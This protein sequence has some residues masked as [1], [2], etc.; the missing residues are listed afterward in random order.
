MLNS[1]LSIHEGGIH[2]VSVMK[3][4][5][6]STGKVIIHSRQFVLFHQLKILYFANTRVFLLLGNCQ[7]LPQKHK[8]HKRAL[9]IVW[10]CVFL[11]KIACQGC[12]RLVTTAT[13]CYFS[14]QEGNSWSARH[15][16]L[17]TKGPRFVDVVAK[18]IDWLKNET[19]EYFVDLGFDRCDGTLPGKMYTGNAN[20]PEIVLL[21][22]PRHPNSSE[23]KSA[24]ILA[25]LSGGIFSWRV[26]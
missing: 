12:G 23:M 4:G 7:T 8:V 15:T 22:L 13:I 1:H 20:G 6:K 21:S 14:E 18:W 26:R 5:G 3:K 11:E 17:H 2:W 25:C 16:A 24:C 10:H 19:R 9:G